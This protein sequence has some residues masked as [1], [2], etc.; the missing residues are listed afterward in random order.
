MFDLFFVPQSLLLTF[1]DLRTVDPTLNSNTP[2]AIYNQKGFFRIQFKEP[3][4]LGPYQGLKE[5]NP[6]LEPDGLYYRNYQIYDLFPSDIIDTEGNTITIQEQKDRYDLEILSQLKSDLKVKVHEFYQNSILAGYQITFSDNSTATLDLSLDAQLKRIIADQTLD[7]Q[8]TI[9]TKEGQKIIDSQEFKDLTQQS[10]K[11]SM[12][13][14]NNFVEKGLM[15]DQITDF[16][17]AYEFESS[18]GFPI[19]IPPRMINIMVDVDGDLFDFNNQPDDESLNRVTIKPA[20]PGE[21]FADISTV[22]WLSGARRIKSVNGVLVPTTGLV[23]AVFDSNNVYMADLY[24]YFN[25]PFIKAVALANGLPKL[26]SDI[27]V[28]F[29]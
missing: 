16:N 12:D 9:N 28:S 17:D 19:H 22:S 7:A 5:I 2:E 11:A 4:I 3:P 10:A 14:E 18:E 6:T 26:M 21:G 23:V 29:S 8:K 15:I 13:I 24:F 20:K 27:E 1:S 25:S